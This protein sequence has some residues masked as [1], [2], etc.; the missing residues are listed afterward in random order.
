MRKF[1]TL[2]ILGVIAFIAYTYGAK[3]GRGRYREIQAGLDALWNDPRVKK[4]RK[5]AVKRA[6]K[7]ARSL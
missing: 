5:Q 4:A 2:L 1:F 6:E 3:A 7:A